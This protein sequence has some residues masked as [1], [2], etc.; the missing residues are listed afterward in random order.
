MNRMLGKKNNKCNTRI[1]VKKRTVDK[2]KYR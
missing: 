2:I 1:N